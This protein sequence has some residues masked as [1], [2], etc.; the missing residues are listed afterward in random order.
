MQSDLALGDTSRSDD[1]RGWWPG[2]SL[3]RVRRTTR[4]RLRY[5]C[6]VAVSPSSP[7]SAR[8]GWPPY[9]SG[10]A[11]PGPEPRPCQPSRR[12]SP[13]TYAEAALTKAAIIPGIS[14]SAGPR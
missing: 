10:I 6:K 3:P 4:S 12:G 7:R 11:S 9:L 5:P 8:T 14:P 1:G 13:D 2:D